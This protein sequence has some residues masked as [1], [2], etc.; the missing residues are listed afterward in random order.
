MFVRQYVVS[1]EEGSKGWW[2]SCLMQVHLKERMHALEEKNN[3]NTELE[4]TKKKLEE[5]TG[6]KV[7]WTQM[8]DLFMQVTAI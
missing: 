3:L 6:Q 2:G 4:N 7:A 5:T 8:L 1:Q